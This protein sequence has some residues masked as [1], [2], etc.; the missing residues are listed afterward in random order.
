MTHQPDPDRPAA[1]ATPRHDGGGRHHRRASSNRRRRALLAL[2]G[3]VAV[4]LVGVVWLGLDALRARDELQTAAGLV[5]ELQAQ[6]LDGDRDSAATTLDRLQEHAAAAVDSAHGPHWSVAAALP[7]VG[8]NVRAVQLVSEVVDGLAQR[9][10][11]GLLA[12]TELVDPAALAPVG[13]RVDLE[14]LTAAAPAVVAADGEVRSAAERIGALDR[15]GLWA[16]V[17]GPLDDLAVEVE[18]VATVTAT[19]ARAVQLL[20]PMLGSDGPREYLLLVQ[21]T[22]EPRATGGIPGAVILLHAEDGVVQ[23]REQRSGGPLV[24]LPAPVLP[25]TRAEQALFGEDLAADIRDVTFTPDFPRSAEIAQA[26]WEQQVGGD[27]DGVLSVDPGALALLLAGTGPVP[28][29]P[30]PVAEAAGGA[31]TA[32]N[33]EQVLLSS[34]YLLLAEPVQ[35]DDFFARTASAVFAA[36]AGGQGGATAAVDGLAE[37]ARQGR[38]MVWSAHPEEQALLAGTVLSGELRGEVDGAPVVGVFLN[39]ANADK[40]GFYLRT[41]VAAERTACRADGG[42]ALTVTVTLTSAAPTSG[43]PSYVTGTDPGLPAGH[44]R[45]NLLLY[46][47]TGGLVE[48]VR[49]SSGEPGVTSQVHDDLAVVGRTVQIG[50]GEMQRLEFDVTT[51][52]GQA[53]AVILR[54]TPGILELPSE[55]G[56]QPCS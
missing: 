20:P 48:D 43:L 52:P 39:D 17:S 54:T 29:D 47:P 35:Q 31:L 56:L 2:S 49:V 25:L 4:L 8:P 30:G 16:S 42:Q 1:T 40:M 15:A 9:A 14:P 46:A 7:V 10:L 27:V 19:A 6:V 32:Q 51:G 22:A 34:V 41:E 5:R 11:P 13:G 23:V 53:E 28:L 24:D 50:P 26:L 38:L 45:M 36:V 55:Q 3:L 37:A 18:D 21:N 12:A 44:L 33:A